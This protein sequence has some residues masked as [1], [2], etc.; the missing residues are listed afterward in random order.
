MRLIELT[1]SL[2]ITMLVCDAMALTVDEAVDYALNN[3]E[4]VL[5]NLNNS[6]IMKAKAEQTISFTKPQMSLNGTVAAL[7]GSTIDD[8]FD[9]NYSVGIN[10]SQVVFSGGRI[11]ESV[12][13][14]DNL[15][16]QAGDIIRVGNREIKKLV[17]KAFYLSLYRKALLLITEDRLKQ[18]QN[19]H[20]DAQNLYSA[21]MVT[22]LDVRQA[23]VNVNK[24]LD[25]VNSSIEDQRESLIDLNLVMGKSANDHLTEL[26]GDYLISVK[27]QNITTELDRR[28]MEDDLLDLLVY[29]EKIEEEKLNYSI[30][31]SERFPEFVLF[32]SYTTGGAYIGDMGDTTMLGVQ[33]NMSILDGGYVKQKRIAYRS[34]ISEKEY[35]YKKARKEFGGEIEKIKQSLQSLQERS[36]LQQEVVELSEM[37]YEDARKK[38]R[39]GT[40]IL[41][42]LEDF[43]LDFNEA[44]FDLLKVNYLQQ[45]VIVDAL[46]LLEK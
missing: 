1:L 30:A 29:K 17:M 40:I 19:E 4:S 26:E 15:S 22:S 12:K 27:T 46:I 25:L 23:K 38:Y 18:K 13:L 20:E 45:D 10:V 28:Y 2:I 7:R 14:K 21:G 35:S 9:S 43:S 42:Q 5:I 31:M 34:A 37:N 6:E 33:M 36:L 32:S 16:L 24:A 41:T 39:T 3:S 11:W 44:R 8:S